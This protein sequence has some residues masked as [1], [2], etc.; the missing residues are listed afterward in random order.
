MG[1]LDDAGIHEQARI[2]REQKQASIRQE[3]E[4][5]CSKSTL[6]AVVEGVRREVRKMFLWDGRRPKEVRLSYSL[7]PAILN[8]GK[9]ECERAVLRALQA[10]ERHV[11]E[12]S[13][14][15]YKGST[16]IDVEFEW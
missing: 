12:V 9:E 7:R 5:F 11:S 6:R 4:D 8:C 14:H 1:F 15:S 16:W 3:I 13:F 2:A 10:E